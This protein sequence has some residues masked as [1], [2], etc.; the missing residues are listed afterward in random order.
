MEETQQKDEEILIAALDDPSQFSLLMD[1]YQRPFLRL[2]YGVVRSHEESEDIV[3][4]AFC[5][6]YRN[7]LKFKKQEG[8]SFKSWAYRVVLNKAISHYRKLKKERE[9]FTALEPAHYENLGVEEG[10][11]ADLDARMTVEKLLDS[12]PTDLQRVVTAYYLEDKSYATIAE[13]EKISLSTLKMRLFRAKRM[14]REFI[15]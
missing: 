14:L 13:E 11:S 6:M 3:Q 1:K 12:L 8:A 7:A 15:T 10:L 9:R 4:E 2:A 5:D